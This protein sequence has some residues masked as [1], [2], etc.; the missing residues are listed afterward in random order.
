M[1][2]FWTWVGEALLLGVGI[3][4]IYGLSIVLWAAGQQ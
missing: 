3:L 1:R 2:T 4:T